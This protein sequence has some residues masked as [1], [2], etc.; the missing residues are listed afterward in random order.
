MPDQP[1]T[2]LVVSPL[3]PFPPVSGGQKRT[4]RLL[5]AMARAGVRPWVLTSDTAPGE[6]VE[7]LR[8]RG[9]EVEVLP[10]APGPGD[11]LAQHAARRPSPYLKPVAARLRPGAAPPAAF[12]QLEHT[13]SAYYRAER[14]G[15]PVLLSL[16]NIDS[17]LAAAAAAVEKTGTPAWL[18]ARVRASATAAQERRAFAHVDRVLCVS[19]EDAAFTA[20]LGG[21]PLVVPNG[22]DGEL[23]EAT[24]PAVEELAVFFG[25]FGYR[26]NRDGL[27][28]FLRDGW[29][30][31]LAARPAARLAVAGPGIGAQERAE[32]EASP[33]VDV[34][35]LVDDLP[36][37]IAR[38]AVVLVPLWEGGGTRLKAL[39]AMAA[40]RPVVGTPLGVERIGFED[41]RH[42][43]VAAD[44]PGLADALATLLGDLPRAAK[45]GEQARAHAERY[46][47]ERVTAELEALYARYAAAGA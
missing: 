17:L 6:H 10:F 29:P 44:A 3:L 12:V 22:V 23:F 42:G 21:S 41:G 24:A 32:L 47:W 39:E 20:A 43:L 11:R 16:H 14:P 15:T 1:A 13:V 46:R 5:E 34:L 8:G 28:R 18:R 27:L 26:P 2:A 40:A 19:D 4:L 25:H 7:A 45:L 37:L 33:G 31:T 35:G 36:A 30:R 38:S 9:W